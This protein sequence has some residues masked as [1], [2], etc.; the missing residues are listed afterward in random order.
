MELLNSDLLEAFV[1]G[2]VETSLDDNKIAGATVAVVSRDKN[3]LIKGYGF[4]NAETRE[5]VDAE[6]HLFRIAS[7]TKTFTATA[8]MQLVQSGDVSLD[9][10]V[11]DYLGGIKLDDHLGTIT[12]ANLL[13]HSAGFEDFNLG[14]YGEAAPGEDP[15]LDGQLEVLADHQVRPP[16]VVTAYSNYGYSLLGAIVG[17]V[18]GLGYARYVQENIFDSLKMHRSTYFLRG[19]SGREDDARLAALR[20]DQAESHTWSQGWYDTQQFPGSRK[21]ILANGSLSTT[22]ADMALYMRMHLNRGAL[23]DVEVLAEPTWTTMSEPLFRNGA[24]AQANA[25][26][27]W[28]TNW[29]GHRVLRHGGSTHD[30]KSELAIFPDLGLGVFVSTNTTTGSKLRR[31]PQRIIQQFF[32]S[33]IETTRPPSP[34]ED[35]SDR[36]HRYTGT[37]INTR[38]NSTRFEKIASTLNAFTDAYATNEGYLVVDDKRYVE[39][40]TDLFQSVADGSIIE[41]KGNDDGKAEWLISAGGSSA[42][43]RPVLFE[44]PV[45]IIAPVVATLLACLLILA[46]GARWMWRRFMHGLGERPSVMDTLFFTNAVGWCASLAILAYALSEYAE[47]SVAFYALPFPSNSLKLYVG[48][49]WLTTLLTAA[50]VVS[51]ARVQIANAWPSRGAAIGYSAAVLA[52]VACAIALSHWNLYSLH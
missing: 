8:I 28:T 2:V 33:D 49:L 44:K 30:F 46:A 40:G 25:H 24:Y 10:D 48:V 42:Y 13:S 1:D 4:A 39:I 37:F 32:A 51:S 3:L 52:F 15:S 7:I 14:A 34:P 20:L 47:S 26:G 9:A 38:R 41:F 29:G 22:A 31:L 45:T 43:Q 21:A 12:V 18:S 19:V 50:C 23:E 16:G 36:A 27:F 5:R 17:K 11:R 6:K 35:F